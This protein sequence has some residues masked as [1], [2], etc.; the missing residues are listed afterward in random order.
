MTFKVQE[1]RFAYPSRERQYHLEN[2]CREITLL[3]SERNNAFEHFSHNHQLLKTCL[4]NENPL[5]NCSTENRGRDLLIRRKRLSIE[6]YLLQLKGL[7]GNHVEDLSLP[8]LAFQGEVHSVRYVE[9]NALGATS[10]VPCVLSLSERELRS[11]SESDDED[12]VV[13]DF[14]EDYE[15]TRLLINISD[16]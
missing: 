12:D 9:E 13:D 2:R 14:S 10:E 1:K 5:E 16:F 6:G 8:D 7:F 11:E 15:T 4:Q 3:S